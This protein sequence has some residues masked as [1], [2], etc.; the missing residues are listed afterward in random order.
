ML[1]VYVLDRLEGLHDPGGDGG[2]WVFALGENE[3][4]GGEVGEE[5]S[6]NEGSTSRVLLH[7]RVMKRELNNP[8]R[9]PKRP[10]ISVTAIGTIKRL[11]RKL[12]FLAGN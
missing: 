10:R 4:S 5:M 7:T 6:I 8:R 2:V 3:D 1:G 11:N 12:T 9:C